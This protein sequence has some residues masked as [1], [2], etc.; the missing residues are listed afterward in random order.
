M[1]KKYLIYTQLLFTF[2]IFLIAYDT[3]INH[4]Y[5]I[6]FNLWVRYYHIYMI[7]LLPL[8]LIFIRTYE[9]DFDKERLR[10]DVLPRFRVLKCCDFLWTVFL[11][12]FSFF[13]LTLVAMLPELSS[14]SFI[15]ASEILTKVKDVSSVISIGVL[16]ST[17]RCV[18]IRDCCAGHRNSDCCVTLT[19]CCASGTDNDGFVLYMCI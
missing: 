13:A 6:L 5:N 11:R 9:R 16:R 2:L 19:D 10:E 8:R 7:N 12:A 3:N 4:R 14:I 15:S 1:S 17:D 18:L